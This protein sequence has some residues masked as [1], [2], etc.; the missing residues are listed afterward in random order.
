M[1]GEKDL[2]TWVAHALNQKAGYGIIMCEKQQCCVV[3]VL[4]L[5]SET[6]QYSPPADPRNSPVRRKGAVFLTIVN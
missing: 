6:T 2:N 4:I 1:N 5:L 3:I